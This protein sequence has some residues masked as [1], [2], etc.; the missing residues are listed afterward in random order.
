[1]CD[2]NEAMCNCYIAMCDCY[3]S[4]RDLV[5]GRLA[6]TSSVS[7]DSAILKEIF[8]GQFVIT[9]PHLQKLL[10]LKSV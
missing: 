1:M 9:G 5:T 2:C 6:G 10:A 4:R 3:A 7:L 8:R